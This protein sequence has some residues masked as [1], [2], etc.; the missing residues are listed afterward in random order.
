MSNVSVK[1][2]FWLNVWLRCLK[3]SNNICLFV[4]LSVCL[5]VCP[6]VCLS[7]C[8][9]HSFITIIVIYTERLWSP[10][11][12][13]VQQESRSPL[14]VKLLQSLCVVYPYTVCK[15]RIKSNSRSPLSVE[16]VKDLIRISPDSCSIE[17]FQQEPVA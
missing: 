11:D 14:T 4:C 6:S 1:T 7:V 16:T 15:N 13:T 3:I 2:F 9:S 17:S 5:S 10:Q 12:V 8:L